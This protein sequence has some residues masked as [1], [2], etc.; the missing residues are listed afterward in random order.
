MAEITRRELVLA[1][2]QIHED[3][4]PR[5]SGVDLSGL[6]LSYLNLSGADLGAANL[7]GANLKGIN[8]TNAFLG[9]ANL[10]NADLT[11]AYLRNAIFQG[12]DLRRRPDERL[13]QRRDL[14]Q[15]SDRGRHRPRGLRPARVAPGL[16]GGG[17]A[18]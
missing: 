12:V 3:L 7:E 6:D 11:D 17:D 13:H 2:I 15:V 10:Q 9:G 18:R 14:P 4:K 16:A 8:L 1:L 5:L